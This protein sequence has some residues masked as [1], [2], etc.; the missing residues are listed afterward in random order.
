MSTQVGVDVGTM[1][2]VCAKRVSEDKVN[3]GIMKNMFL[4]IDPSFISSSEM[5]GTDLDYIEQKDENGVV[6]KIFVISEDAFK[7][8]N[9]FGREVNRPMSD[10]VISTSE[11]DAIDVLTLM[12]E[13]LVGR[14]KSGTVVY[15]IPAQ[16]VDVERPP[17]EY[18]RDVF[19]Q[20]FESLGFKPS[21][22]NEALAIIYSE[23]KSSNYTGIA[24]SFGAGLTNCCCSYKGQPVFQFAV[25]M[26]GD[27]IDVSSAKSLNVPVVRVT[28][29][30]EKAFSFKNNDSK[31]KQEKRIK[32][33]IKCYYTEL[34]NHVLDVF[35][36]QFQQKSDGLYI[37]EAIPIIISGGTT[38]PEGFLDFFKELFESVDDFP[39]NI[40]EIRS[41]KDPLTAVARG[42]L[43]YASGLDKKK[44]PEQEKKDDTNK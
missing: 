40:S 1:H 23:C 11:V 39:Y 35:K 22:I 15:S 32:S 44:K 13:K 17:I 2:C 12:F 8:A 34:V 27:W 41:A 26:G 42:C 6:E 29:I 7:I 3:I 16:A 38:M 36:D 43:L 24:I 18:H 5:E 9:V 37:D 30:K 28:H 25:G 20:I 10:G 21:S 33:A 14:S 19:K 4:D 31:N